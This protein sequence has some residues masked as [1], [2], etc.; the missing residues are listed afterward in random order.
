[1]TEIRDLKSLVD[2]IGISYNTTTAAHQPGYGYAD[3]Y[4]QYPALRKGSFIAVYDNSCH[5]IFIGYAQI[6]DSEWHPIPGAYLYVVTF[7][8]KGNARN[9]WDFHA[10]PVDADEIRQLFT[11]IRNRYDQ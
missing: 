1:M 10:R 3:A 6:T 2:H 4:A 8:Q 7:C 5:S 11:L 9:V